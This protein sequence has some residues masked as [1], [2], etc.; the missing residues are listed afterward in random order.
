M[1]IESAVRLPMWWDVVDARQTRPSL[2]SDIDVDVVVVGAGFTGLWAAYH[3][4]VLDPALRV[5]V[6]EAQYVGFGASGRNGGWC[7]AEYPLGSDQLAKDHGEERALD[8]MRSLFESVDDVGS[9]SSEEG[10]DCDYAKGG[11][12]TVARQAFQDSYA[13]EEVEHSRRLGLSGDDIRYLSG[14][15]ARE[16]LNATDVVSGVWF[17]H[18]AAIQ[19]AKLVHGLADAVERRGVEIYES[20]PAQAI[21]E[22]T[23]RTTGGT[24]S[25]EIVVLA[26]EGF[27]SQLPGRARTVI[28]LYSLMIATEPL[29][30]DSWDEIGLEDRQTFGDFRNLI[31]YGQRTGDGRLAFG[32]RGAPYHFGSSIEEPYDIDDGV[33]AELARALVELFPHLSDAELTH[34]W[35]GPLGVARDWKPAVTI[36]WASGLAVA[37]GYVG[38]GVA[39]AQLA[40]RTLAELITRTDTGRTSL[41]WVQHQWP[42]WEPEPLRWIGINFGLALTK[43]ADRRE[44]KRQAPSRLSDSGNW[45]RG[46]R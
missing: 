32:G 44:R 39:T 24:V 21:G 46:K 4:A 22:R 13:R 9:I 45:L 11:V 35:G 10:I 17:A 27:G 14:S 3:L 41:P 38:D 6:I 37:G 29:S 31:I 26:T 42:R 33:H 5:A 23:V 25:A 1:N 20:T 34:R 7:H 15:E 36:D 28:P 30:D 8:H 43:H 19:P 12:L 40:G 2:R 16:M 18:G